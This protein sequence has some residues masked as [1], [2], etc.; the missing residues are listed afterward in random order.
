MEFGEILTELTLVLN[1]L[2]R[3]RICSGGH[4]LS[5]CFVLLCIPDG[6]ID[7]ST[8]SSTLGLDN[9]TTTRLVDTV[10]KKGL[11]RREKGRED[12]RVTVVLLTEKGEKLCRQFEE[13][14][15]ALGEEVLQNMSQEKQEQ[16][17]ESLE[18][19]LWSLSKG[20]LGHMP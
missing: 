7:M 19:V 14:V 18:T 17:H 12:R 16:I 5:Q 13:T 10:G 9:S 6:G 2:H 11:I 15:D 1:A 3:Q 4:T 8:L 20:K